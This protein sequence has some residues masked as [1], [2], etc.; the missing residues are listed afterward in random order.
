M[1]F[2]GHTEMDRESSTN[3]AGS[4]ILSVVMAFGCIR[5]AEHCMGLW[6]I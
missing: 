1:L 6:I 2:Y 3:I 4:L 5:P